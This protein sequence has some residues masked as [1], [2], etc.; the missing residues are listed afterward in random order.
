MSRYTVH[1]KAVNFIV[2]IPLESAWPEEQ[3]DELYS[4]LFGGVG[5]AGALSTMGDSVSEA[6][7]DLGGLR[8]F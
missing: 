5:K 3:V 6:V 7:A 2:P 1:D 8:V 4:S